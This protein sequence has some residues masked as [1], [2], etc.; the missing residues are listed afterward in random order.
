MSAARRFASGSVLAYMFKV[1]A[2]LACPRLLAAVL[3]SPPLARN[4]V[5]HVWRKS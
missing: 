5:A 4:I 1:I 3:T 2:A